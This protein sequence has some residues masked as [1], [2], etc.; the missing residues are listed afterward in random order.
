M[1]FR[2]LTQRL[3][4]K[5]AT[6][7]HWPVPERDCVEAFL[8][9]FLDLTF[10]GMLRRTYADEAD[11]EEAFR[12]HVENLDRLLTRFRVEADR[13]E[14]LLTAYPQQLLDL[15]DAIEADAQALFDGDPAASSIEEVLACYP[16][17]HAVAT[18]R[19]AHHFHL[20]GLK[21]LPRMLAEIAHEKTGIDIHPGATIGKSF[22]IDHGTGVVIGETSTIGDRVK[23]Y[24][25]VTLG[26][27]SVSKEMAQ[28]KRHPTIED[29]CVIY[30]QATILG[31]DTVIG[32]NS[33]IGGNV[34]I[35]S[36]VPAASLVYHQSEV[37]LGRVGTED[38]P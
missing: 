3:F 30:S 6:F 21:L 2:D 23:L 22:F 13:R 5:K 7:L 4:R 27:L 34:W 15:S 24:Q 36:S 29:D 14:T 12:E 25:G 11:F 31:G 8:T 33:V 18:Y 37:K 9:D 35:T 20:A 38:A 19:L 28:T 32:K 17:L 1:S 26:A 16:G 10:P